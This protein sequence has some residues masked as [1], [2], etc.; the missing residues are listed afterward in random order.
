MKIGDTGRMT[1]HANGQDGSGEA[2][3]ITGEA[4]SCADVERV[5]V[6]RQ[7]VVLSEETCDRISRSRST[8]EK[9]ISHGEAIYGV[10]TGFG[11]LSS[12]RLEDD[13][14]EALQANLIRSHAAG[15]GRPFDS[16]IVRGTLLLLAASLSRGHSGVR[17]QTVEAI[18]GLLNSA[19]EGGSGGAGVVPV[20]P[21]VGSVGASGDLA[22]LAHCVL[23]L[24]GEGEAFFDGVRMDAGE[25]LAKAGLAPITLGSKEGLALIN[26]THLMASR[27]ALIL[28]KADRVLD[29]ALVACAMSIEGLQAS[30]SFLDDRVHVARNQPGQRFVAARLRRQLDGSE[31]L[32]SHSEDDHRVQD[33]YSFRASPQVVGAAVDLLAYARGAIE[34]ELGAVTDNPLVFGDGDGPLVRSA[35]NFH[36][37]PVALPLDALAPAFTHI[38]ATAE[39]R[40][41]HLLATEFSLKKHGK[42]LARTPGVE[43][44]LMIT[45]YTAAACVNEMIGLSNPSSVAN[46]TTDAGMED[47]NSFGPRSAAKAERAL[48]LLASVVAIELLVSAEAIEY[49]RPMKSGPGVE[50]AHRLIR[51]YVPRLERDRSPSPDIETLKLLVGAGA[52]GS[53]CV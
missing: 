45:Q 2:L 20:V 51:E 32:A 3:V 4:L 19:G 18:V 25:A 50:K 26:G 42:H 38:A 16:G 48:D 33:P 46:V 43:S 41:F 37:M 24:M 36:G 44:G 11:S 35:A 47:Y 5:A 6:H 21:E 23:T 14:L 13:Q 1:E 8:L 52:F 30:D 12:T 22:P 34:R 15:V 7:R 27:G 31:I 40:V 53:D 17:V 28:A 49:Q 10:N 29:S 9:A 39:R